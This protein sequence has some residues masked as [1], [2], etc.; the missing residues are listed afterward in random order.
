M[1]T[2]RERF[3]E[4]YVAYEEPWKNKK[5]FRIQYEYVGP[6]YGYKLNEEEKKRYKRIFLGLCILSTFFY[7]LAALQKYELN[8]RSFPVL[9]IGL[10]MAAFLFEWF[11]I[12]KFLLA[13]EKL[14][15]ENF[16]EMDGILKIVPYVNGILLLGAAISGSCMLIGSRFSPGMWLVPLFYLLAG[17]CSALIGFFYQALPYEKRK[18]HALDDD[19]KNRIPM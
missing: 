16:K 19:S 8:T 15:E 13:G 6:W 9:F 4:N 5:G 7:T 14:T 17:S 12:F 11:G 10:S 18:N 2:F 3:E 1:K